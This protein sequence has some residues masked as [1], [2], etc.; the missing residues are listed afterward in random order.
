M[1][2]L[3]HLALLALLLVPFAASCGDDEPDPYAVSSEVGETC[4]RDADCEDRCID[5]WPG[6]LC[7]LECRTHDGCPADTWC[8]DTQGGVCLFSCESDRECLDRL[9]DGYAC[10]RDEDFSGRD[11]FVCKKK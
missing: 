7:T 2:R 5:D 6:G 4:E 1:T 3:R 8:V 9:G 11:R 10:K